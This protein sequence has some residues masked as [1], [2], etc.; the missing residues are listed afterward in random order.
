[1]IGAFKGGILMGLGNGAADRGIRSRGLNGLVWVD[2]NDSRAIKVNRKIAIP[3]L[4]GGG[5]A[6]P[7]V[8][9][10]CACAGGVF[11]RLG[12]LGRFRILGYGLLDLAGYH[13]EKN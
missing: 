6:I 7:I 11:M 4:Q 3:M 10:L 5:G 9:N 1:M 12:G 2:G 8:R 13:R